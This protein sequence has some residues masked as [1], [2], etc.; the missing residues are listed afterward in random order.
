M[1][2]MAALGRPDGGGRPEFKKGPKMDLNLIL[3][4][5]QNPL[6]K[7]VVADFVLNL[8]IKLGAEAIEQVLVATPIVEMLQLHLTT[9]GP[10]A[11]LQHV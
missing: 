6:A 2:E 9:A 10:T 8:K 5:S 3:N 1:E 7:D 11:I 4:L